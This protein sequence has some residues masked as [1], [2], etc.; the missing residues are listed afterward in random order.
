MGVL[1]MHSGQSSG[2]NMEHGSRS[3]PDIGT[4][5]VID[6]GRRYH[7]QPSHGT[8]KQELAMSTTTRMAKNRLLDEDAELLRSFGSRS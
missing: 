1:C 6:E 2:G 7:I 5:I 4:M 3:Q 8:L